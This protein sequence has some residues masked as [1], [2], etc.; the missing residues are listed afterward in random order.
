MPPP[1]T[2][3]KTDSFLRLLFLR[4]LADELQI[5]MGQA[6]AEFKKIS[7]ILFASA[8]AQR[9]IDYFYRF[10]SSLVFVVFRSVS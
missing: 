9:M 7:I 1:V 2:R 3:A 5:L 4:P 10:G 6:L 8:K